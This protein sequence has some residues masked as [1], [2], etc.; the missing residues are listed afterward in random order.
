MHLQAMTESF[1]LPDKLAV[2]IM[3]L[4]YPG[5]L[6]DVN[7]T[8]GES[9]NFIVLAG[10]HMHPFINSKILFPTRSSRSL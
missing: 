2:K 1:I 4:V 6:S 7:I 3:S 5:N 8:L 10:V 9:S